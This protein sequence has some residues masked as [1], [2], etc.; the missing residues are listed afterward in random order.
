MKSQCLSSQWRRDKFAGLC[1][2]A[3]LDKC[4]RVAYIMDTDFV[5]LVEI[6]HTVLF[7]SCVICESISAIFI[8]VQYDHEYVD[9]GNTLISLR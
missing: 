9:I 8:A 3:V 5:E 4:L 6:D 1:N 2:N 7:Y